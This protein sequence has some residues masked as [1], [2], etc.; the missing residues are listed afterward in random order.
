M[1]GKSVLRLIVAAAA[2]LPL[3]AFAQ[4]YLG[5]GAGK[6]DNKDFCGIFVATSCNK[7]GTTWRGFAGFLFTPN[8]GA[9]AGYAA[10]GKYTSGDP[11]SQSTIEP[12]LGDVQAVLRYPAGRASVFARLGAYY[13]HTELNQQAGGV[14][15]VT[16]KKSNGGVTYGAGAQYDFSA[17]GGFGLRV[18]FQHY[19]RVGGN[20]VGG[21]MNINTFVA[22]L[23]YTLR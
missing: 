6:S 16:S 5:I 10:L 8:L 23:V 14:T 1:N 3:S 2:A 4:L 9:E 17:N 19:Q 20:D 18:D 13:G 11:G 7:S 21:S 22:S 15:V 12:T